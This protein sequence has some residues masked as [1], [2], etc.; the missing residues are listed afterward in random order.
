MQKHF[1]V[2]SETLPLTFLP[3]R[4][5]FSS[6]YVPKNVVENKAS[7]RG[8]STTRI[9]KGSSKIAY[10]AQSKGYRDRLYMY[11]QRITQYGL[12]LYGQ[13]SISEGKGELFHQ[14]ELILKKL[15]YFQKLYLSLR[16][17]KTLVPQVVRFQKQFNSVKFNSKEGSSHDSYKKSSIYRRPYL[18]KRLL[19][20]YS[21]RHKKISR[22]QQ[23]PR[24][25]PVHFFIPAYLQRDFR[26]LS[27]VK[28]QSPGQ[29][30]IYYPFRISL[31]QIHSFYRSQGF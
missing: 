15:R 7:F 10:F 24:L 29:E 28:I 8:R 9:N 3:H 23:F 21:K 31:A 22:A 11:S 17:R 4:S 16:V 20:F 14:A 25:K 13:E 27:A 2:G 30:E 5:F 18:R 12:R 6:L 26:T 1:A 19:R